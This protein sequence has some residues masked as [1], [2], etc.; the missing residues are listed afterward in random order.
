MSEPRISPKIRKQI[1]KELCDVTHKRPDL[2]DGR[3]QVAEIIEKHLGTEVREQAVSG[4]Y[5]GSEGRSFQPIDGF[6]D[7][8]VMDWY[9]SKLEVAYMS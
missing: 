1:N 4:F 5:C 2:G 3:G 6:N 9:N 8:L 7:A